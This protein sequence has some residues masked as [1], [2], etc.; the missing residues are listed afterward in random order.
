MLMHEEPRL[1]H[2]QY[3]ETYIW[4]DIDLYEYWERCVCVC[5]CIVS[6]TGDILREFDYS[7]FWAMKVWSANCH[8]LIVSNK[9]VTI[10]AYYTSSMF[11]V[12]TKRYTYWLFVLSIYTV[13]LFSL[14]IPEDKLWHALYYL[15]T[16]YRTVWS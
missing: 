15:K 16:V 8:Q 5:V 1:A 10:W 3:I 7:W 4:E 11:C 2:Q 12:F 9:F 13:Q 14:I 6:F